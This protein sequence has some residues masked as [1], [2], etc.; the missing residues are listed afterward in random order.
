M[1]DDRYPWQGLAA[2]RDQPSSCFF[3]DEEGI[4]SRTQYKEVCGNCPVKSLCLESSLLDNF[5]GVWGGLTD[6]ER[7]IMYPESYREQLREEMQELG[8]WSPLPYNRELA[9]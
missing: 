3:L 2:C 7:L 8:E 6:K 4:H 5:E 1:K 9:S